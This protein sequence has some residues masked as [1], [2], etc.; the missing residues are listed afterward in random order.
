MSILDEFSAEIVEFLYRV[1]GKEV[2]D[3]VI[4]Y[5]TDKGYSPDEVK[6]KDRWLVAMLDR[7]RRYLLQGDD[8]N[9]HSEL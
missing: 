7:Q 5:I 3:A 9:N 4:K 2:M 6:N 1:Y 8:I